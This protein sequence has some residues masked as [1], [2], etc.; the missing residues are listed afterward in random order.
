MKTI[1]RMALAIILAIGTNL[2]GIGASKSYDSNELNITQT[3]KSGV[4]YNRIS[5][6]SFISHQD[7]GAPELP[8]EYVNLIIPSNMDV[9][10][11]NTTSNS[12]IIE[13]SY[14]IYPTQ[15]PT[16]IGCPVPD[17][18][19][20]DSE[21]YNSNQFYPSLTAEIEG[22]SYIAGANKIVTIK[23]NPLQYNPVT[24]ELKLNS[25]ISFSLN[26]TAS[27]EE[28]INPQKRFR[29]D[30]K[31]IDSY[32]Y[33][34]IENKEEV[35]LY[36]QAPTLIDSPSN[37]EYNYLIVA[38]E[39]YLPPNSN[40]LEKFIDW[41]ES[42]GNFVKAMSYND[43]YNLGY[44]SD[45]MNTIPIVD[46]AGGL[47]QFLRDE[48][49]YKGLT[50]VLLIGDEIN[51]PIRY[52]QKTGE[53]LSTGI[54][55]DHYFADFNSNWNK[56]NSNSSYYYG[57]DIDKGKELF[58]GRIIVPNNA[59]EELENWIYKTLTYEQNPGHGDRDYIK[60]VFIESADSVYHSENYFYPEQRLGGYLE[61][62]GYN[63]EFI[64]E[65]WNSATNYLWP[66]GKY[67]VN[68]MRDNKHFVSLDCHGSKSGVGVAT[69]GSNGNNHD[70]PTN[71]GVFGDVNE[72]PF[73][74]FAY[75]EDGTNDLL[76]NFVGSKYQI[77][78]SSSCHNAAFDYVDEGGWG[79]SKV[80]F[81]RVFTNGSKNTCGPII[82][83]N[84]RCG[85]YGSSPR[86][87][88]HFFEVLLGDENSIN[89]IYPSNKVGVTEASSKNYTSEYLAMSSTLFGDPDLD[90][91]TE[92]PEDMYIVIN[93]AE[94]QVEVYDFENNPV[95]YVDLTFM[96]TNGHITVNTERNNI[97]SIPVS[98][99]KKIVAVKQNYIPVS[100]RIISTD[101]TI[102]TSEIIDNNLIVM[103][104][105]QLTIS[106]KD[107]KFETG[108]S[109]Q[110][111]G[112]AKVKVEDGGKIYFEKGS[113]ILVDDTSEIIIANGGEFASNGNGTERVKFL[114]KTTN[115]WSGIECYSGSIINIQG[116]DFINASSAIHGAPSTCNILFSKFIDCDKAI[117]IANSNDY[118]I[119]NNEIFFYNPTFENHGQVGISL[120]QCETGKL[121]C[122]DIRD[123]KVGIFV[124]NSSPLLIRN[125]VK[126]NYHYGLKV[127][128]YK[129]IPNLVDPY[130]IVYPPYNNTISDNGV[131]YVDGAQIYIYG[132]GKISLDSGNNNIYGNLAGGIPQ[133]PCVKIVKNS[134]G[135]TINL[136]AR[137]N[138]WGSSNVTDQFFTISPY[139][140]FEY[141]PWGSSSY[142]INIS[143]TITE[144]ASIVNEGIENEDKENFEMAKNLYK[145]VISQYP[146]SSESYVA[147][148]RLPNTYRSIGITEY[149][150]LIQLLNEKLSDDV[151][152]DKDFLN[153]M[154]GKI[155]FLAKNYQEAELMVNELKNSASSTPEIL[156]CDIDIQ[157]IENTQNNGKAEE[158]VRHNRL[159]KEVNSFLD[160][161]IGKG[162]EGLELNETETIPNTFSLSQNYPNPFNPTTT[163]SF[164]LPMESDVKL[165]VYNTK[166]EMVKN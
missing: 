66:T 61:N 112:G 65:I 68:R 28:G 91:W 150:E 88:R 136:K 157:I 60:N 92:V 55:A 39:E 147:I 69:K 45:N 111:Y 126:N 29:R 159:M 30:Q 144:A 36:K 67:V 6:G 156:A 119:S 13:G 158:S 86:L 42:K 113:K 103:P 3:I 105:V 49:E 131:N 58:V 89:W 27:Q 25:S 40:V 19:G 33:S 72:P 23:L 82:I 22:Y 132:S 134:C 94:N 97:A 141:S 90:I 104:N 121:I 79:D 51:S 1:L 138:Y 77:Y 108:S 53:S 46:N 74:P 139:Y 15:P 52:Y 8:V 96:G 34:S 149:E 62:K 85:W 123:N 73:S 151:W 12:E 41:K 165:E 10:S 37:G 57:Y 87:R 127:L 100:N 11:L 9:A 75:P 20:E 54:L 48:Y 47:R 164:N 16:P 43:I 106:A 152:K 5:L 26:L 59:E 120:I 31:F 125:T 124:T 162:S 102:T 122:N 50:Y 161:L 83:A 116:T 154:M 98:S 140:S 14:N 148:T 78:H 80:S 21:I 56:N 17:Y 24:D 109:L 4:T 35:E 166:G 146:N 129:A 93:E 44:N 101:Q 38:P 7:E 117:N 64:T 63:F 70:L 133:K 160:K 95:N 153:E 71:Y 155:E 115:S 128:G 135:R 84:T 18:V 137:W 32:I 145:Q 114:N 99:Y 107:F 142:P 110:L 76:H 2:F 130:N 81:A 118:R 143:R 163:I